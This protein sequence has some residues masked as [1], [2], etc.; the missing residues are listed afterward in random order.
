[1]AARTDD[2]KAPA[3]IS[4]QGFERLHWRLQYLI[5]VARLEVARELKE[6]ASHGYG[7]QNLELKTAR[8]KHRQLEWSIAKLLEEIAL[9]QVVVSP[10]PADGRVHFGSLV[11]LL[12]L[13]RDREEVYRIVGRFESD[14]AQ[15]RLS[16]D[17]PLG[18]AVAEAKAGALVEVQTPRGKVGY[19]VLEVG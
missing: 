19:L 1:M 12:N 4:R 6:A 10:P 7:L 18:Q 3:L 17:S 8:E 9:C 11:R 2:K 16:M 5:R 14:P 15:G 13:D